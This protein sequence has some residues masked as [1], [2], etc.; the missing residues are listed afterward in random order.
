MLAFRDIVV[1]P[2]V[3]YLEPPRHGGFLR[4]GPRWPEWSSQ[5]AARHCQAGV[6]VDHEPPEAKP[7]ST[8]KGP[9]AWGGPVTLHFGH[10]VAD[11][12]TRWLPT[13]AEMPDARFAFTT[14]ENLIDRIRSWDDLPQHF[15]AI[16]DWYG[17]GAER[18]DFITEPTLVE[19][20]VVAPQAEQFVGPG[21]EPWYL[22]MLD[23]HARSRLGEVERSGSLYVSRA[24]LRGGN[25]AGEAYLETVLEQAGFRVLRPEAIPIEDQMRAYAGADSVVFAEGSALHGAQLMGRALGDV[26]VLIRRHGWRLAQASLTPRARSVHYA[27]VVRGV[28]HGRTMG[29]MAG[30]WRGLSILDPERLFAALPVGDAW[31]PKTFDAAVDA[32]VR[33][34]LETE[35]AS[36]RWEVPGAPELVAESLRAV[37]LGHL[38]PG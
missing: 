20:L 14:R 16:L 34:W 15:R 4:G 35:R 19:R 25:F 12:S 26:T 18:L 3:D 22:D 23:A 1:T 28:V 2:Y 8:L 29:G 37:G 10:Q 17:I 31:D 13:L 5:T 7:T 21:P 27:D 38:Y 9:V 33:E 36:Q 11:V 30:L 24:G 6:P 32:D